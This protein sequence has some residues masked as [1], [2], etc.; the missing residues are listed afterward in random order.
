M[1]DAKAFGTYC[2]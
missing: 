2:L 1:P